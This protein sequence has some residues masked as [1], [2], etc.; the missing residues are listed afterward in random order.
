MSII[1]QF[2]KLQ[3]SNLFF[4]LLPLNHLVPV[5][6][7]IPQLILLLDDAGLEGVKVFLEKFIF[8]P[9]ECRYAKHANDQ[10]GANT[11]HEKSNQ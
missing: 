10:I 4:N 6:Q 8:H 1:G 7:L 3:Y 11:V 5:L 2:S 9:F